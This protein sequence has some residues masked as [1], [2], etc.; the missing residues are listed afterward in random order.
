M[1]LLPPDS[2]G[3]RDPGKEAAAQRQRARFARD[4]GDEHGQAWSHEPR[5]K[6]SKL[7]IGTA[8]VFIAFIALGAL[9]MLLHKGDGGLVQPNCDTVALGAGPARTKLGTDIAW[10]IAGPRTGPYV[11][12]LD[13]NTV[14]GPATGPVTVDTGRVL[15]GPIGLPDCR[16]A[17]TVTDG[18]SSTGDHEVTLFRR[19]GSGWERVA[20]TSLAVS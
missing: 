14:T 2:T 1:A 5:R 11:V 12:A 8:V 4:V 17:Q 20:V 6:R 19:S 7:T 9:P 18:P 15:A 10:Q 13:S 3:R 16:S